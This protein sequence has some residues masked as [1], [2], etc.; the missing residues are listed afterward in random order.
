MMIIFKSEEIGNFADATHNRNSTTFILRA[1]YLKDSCDSIVELSVLNLELFK[2]RRTVPND[3][4][5]LKFHKLQRP[6]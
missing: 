5:S 6:R 2:G 4:A 1:V 3:Y